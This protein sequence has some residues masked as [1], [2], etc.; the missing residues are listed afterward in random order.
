MVGTDRF[1]I[2]P[3]Q[4]YM[5]RPSN[6]L[7]T[8][9]AVVCVHQCSALGGCAEA[10]EDVAAA[11]CAE[12]LV[13][14]SFDLR[15]AGSSSGCCCMWPIPLLSGCP[16]VSDVVRVCSWVRSEL[17]RDTWICGVSAGGPVGAGA[18]DAL[19]SIRG[20][21]SVAYT[22]GLVTSLLFL[23]QAR[24]TRPLYSMLAQATRPGRAPRPCA[25][26]AHRARSLC[27]LPACRRRCASRA[28]PSPS[29]SSWA[30]GTSSPPSPPTSFGS[31]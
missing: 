19:D 25:H 31:R 22:L 27:A 10:V 1:R 21:T 29:S 3:L 4:A 14:I 2:G 13:V 16:E 9:I 17:G 8:E 15:G 7:H 18:I 24:R 11:V 23:P 30:R 26:R 20:Y 5:H 6:D 12:G 28:R